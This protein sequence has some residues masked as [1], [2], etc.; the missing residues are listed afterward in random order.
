MKPC[1][2][3]RKLIAWLALDALDARN[4]AALH[5]HLALCEGCRRYWEEI[6]NVTA[7]LASATADSKLEASESF[8]HRVAEKLRA[9][10]SSSVL[11]NVA[12]WVRG[13]RLNW[14]VALPAI[15][16]LVMVLFA[17]VGPRHHPAHSM[18]AAPALQVVAATGSGSDL[19][20][21]IA[22]YQMIAGQSLERFSELLTRQGNKSLPPA[23]VYTAWSLGLANASY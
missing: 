13:L 11:E 16:V 12:A 2:K 5:D 1:S 9:V 23:P 8:Q 21:T 20:P 14:R 19:A 4:A 3:N 15:A 6:S 17:V 22:N 18:P 10:E 7:G